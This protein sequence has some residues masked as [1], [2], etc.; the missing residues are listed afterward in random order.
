MGEHA[1][2]NVES[3][4]APDGDEAEPRLAAEASAGE[5][6]PP[7]VEAERLV[8]HGNALRFWALAGVASAALGTVVLMASRASPRLVVP[9]AT[10]LVLALVAWLCDFLGSFDDPDQTVL[11]RVRLTAGLLLGGHALDAASSATAGRA[12][13]LGRVVLRLAHAPG[14]WLPLGAGLGYALVAGAV[15]GKV[16]PAVTAVGVPLAFLAA[17]VGVY[18]L[19]E[20]LGPYRRDERGEARPLHRRHGFWLV[21][22][23]TVLYLP[24][25]GN[26]GLVDP[27]ETHYGE[28]SREI[29]ARNDWISLWWAQEGWFFS[30]PV[31]LFWMQSAAMAAGGVRYEP[32]AMLSAAG[33]GD[34][35]QPEWAVR[36]PIFLVTV[37][38]TYV[39]YKGVAKA[40][41]RRAGLLGGLVLLT[42]PQFFLVSHQ[43]MTDMPFVALTAGAIG[44]LLLGLEA[45]PDAEVA[46]YEI[47]LGPRKLRLSA[48]HLVVGAILCVA[49][50]QI[51]YLAS[52]NFSL[53]PLGFVTDTFSSGSPGN[54]GL[55]GNEACRAGLEPSVR[56][57]QPIVQALVWVQALVLFLWPTWGERREKRIAYLAAWLFAALAFMAKGPAGLVFPITSAVFAVVAT[58]RFRELARMEIPAGLLAFATLS[59]PWFVA[60]YVRHGAAFTDNLVFHHFVKRAFEHVH[61]TN[62]GDDVSFRYYV[63]QLG[64][65]TFPW[66]GLVPVAA[67]RLW[68]RRGPGAPGF[69]EA[70]RAEAG[71][72]SRAG[73]AVLVLGSYALAGFAL[74]SAMGTKFHHYCLPILPPLAM[75]AGV[76]LDDMWGEAPGAAED[77]RRGLPAAL[78]RA[79]PAA[80][81]VG[82]GVCLVLGV[83]FALGGSLTGDGAAPPSAGASV[84]CLALAGALFA[85]GF[86]LG[87]RERVARGD[88]APLL[89]AVTA[90][91]ALATLLVGRDL[92]VRGLGRA[93]DVRLMHLFTYNYKRPWPGTLDFTAPLSGFT[94]G[95]AVCLFLASFARLR[96]AA[97][98]GLFGVGCLFAAWGLDVY[99]VRAAPHWG[100]REL[101]VAYER[102][103]AKEPGQLVAYQMNWKGENFYRGNTVP[104]FVQSGQKFTSFIT[105]E[106]A[107][108]ERVFYFV[109]EHGR[110][111]SLANE[112]G[113]PESF[114]TLT[115]PELDNKFLLV[116]VVF[117]G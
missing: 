104:A 11:H 38:G 22:A 117:D 97:L 76:L 90:G 108:G 19:G 42:M 94:V 64:Y 2:D 30:K 21:V 40:A 5:G 71:G 31:L 36:M 99:L 27:W 66:V 24:M 85:G 88:D 61:D 25:L 50:P 62:T 15:A 112:L 114:E 72:A 37:L 75:L 35:P 16:P 100:Q 54:C 51:L 20:A 29:L 32:G 26:H 60:M 6:G 74:F 110:T 52:R 82:A 53:A 48:W 68:R 103:R 78:R 18:R 17:V 115:T 39:L 111:D 116:R 84:A 9:L 33:L 49:L 89:G 3:A 105:A 107:K 58:R 23:A 73:D 46:R 45:D 67:V 59:L 43:T 102:E 4:A 44:C 47:G 77:G 12:T 98:A 13:S 83:G 109:T 96:R 56:M 86:A 91:A 34:T 10:L 28:V 81:A 1:G 41:G 113:R 55:P 65:G 106:R 93:A 80:L 92:A 14:L 87:P 63:W 57:F 69:F 101:F 70:S 8:P 7:S 95:A 79:A